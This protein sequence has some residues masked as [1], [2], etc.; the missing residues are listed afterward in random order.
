MSD[1]RSSIG[2]AEQFVRYCI[3]GG[4]GTCTHF[5]I[6]IALV[7]WAGVHPTVASIIGFVA[8]F[9]VSYVLNRSWVFPASARSWLSFVR[10]SVVCLSGLVLNTSIMVVTVDWLRWYYLWGLAVVVAVVPVT[11][12]ALNRLWAFP[13]AQ[14]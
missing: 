14:N 12:F 9:V 13:V 2:V 5:G 8:A 1:S 6:T 11:N 3:V 7:E 10:Y 4:I